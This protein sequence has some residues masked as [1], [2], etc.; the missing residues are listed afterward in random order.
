MYIHVCVCLP[1]KIDLKLPSSF[2]QTEAARRRVSDV[3]GPA[4]DRARAA[5]AGGGWCGGPGR[6]AKAAA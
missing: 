5:A 6:L 3:T 2:Q 4:Q 1:L